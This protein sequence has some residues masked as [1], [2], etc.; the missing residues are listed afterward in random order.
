M[1]LEEMQSRAVSPRAKQEWETDARDYRDLLLAIFKLDI[2][3][4]AVVQGPAVAGGFGLVL[5]C[6]LVL[7][8]T[9]ARFALPETKRGISPAVV[10]PLLLYRAGMGAASPVILAGESIS[11][12][13]AY[14][15][16][17]CHYLV[18]PAELESARQKI[19]RSIL[20][21]APGATALTKR[22]ARGFAIESLEKQLAAGMQAS[23]EAR[24]TEEAREG[25][26]AFLER[27]PPAWMPLND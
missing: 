26:A 16:L 20:E 1:D 23:A 7:A 9:S 4:L 12:E 6:D 15:L 22:L 8:S 13:E 17:L 14:R 10:S 25:L 27:R 5:A 24:E 18:A 21:G 3:T 2:P 11:A 19:C